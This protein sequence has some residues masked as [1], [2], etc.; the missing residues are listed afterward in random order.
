M[1]WSY[2]FIVVQVSKYMILWRVC[3]EST[4]LSICR[5]SPL[6]QK[7]KSQF[8]SV[9]VVTSALELLAKSQ[10]SLAQ[11]NTLKKM[12]YNSQHVLCDYFKQMLSRMCF[13]SVALINTLLTLFDIIYLDGVG[14]CWPPFNYFN[15]FFTLS[16][17]YFFIVLCV[18]AFANML[19]SNCPSRDK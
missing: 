16:Y 15:Y 6:C 1:M 4:F 13:R 18:V 19:A 10:R 5:F 8:Q 11:H 2:L 3:Y 14:Y 17:L 7:D 9:V 12:M